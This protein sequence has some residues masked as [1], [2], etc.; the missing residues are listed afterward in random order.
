[1]R[2]A[3]QPSTLELRM[4]AYASRFGA[5]RW[6]G[7]FFAAI[8]RLGDGAAW[9]ALMLALAVFGGSRG[10]QAALHMLAT[11]IV[12][13]LLYRWVKQ[14]TRRPRPYRASALVAAHTLALDEFS[15]PS[16]HTLHAVSF[17]LIAIGYFPWLAAPMLT[18]TTLV[19]MSRV[20]LGLHY[21]SDVLVSIIAGTAL[22]R[23]SLWL[24]A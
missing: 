7:A 17:S 16:G 4:C 8:S 14:R 24:L 10:A 12:A 19:A 5:R 21:P 18:F 3:L 1:M 11:G 6:I 2:S 9:Y 22:A 23:T 15:F 13:L 20:V